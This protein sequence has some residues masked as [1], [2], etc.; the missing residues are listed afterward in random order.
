MLM[1]MQNTWSMGFKKICFEG[2][3][4]ILY[5]EYIF[6]VMFVLIVVRVTFVS[7]LMRWIIFYKGES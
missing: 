5:L 3:N 2:K 1:H 6:W 7:M 4:F